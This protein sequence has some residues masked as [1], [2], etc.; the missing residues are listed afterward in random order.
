VSH[1]R[2]D[3]AKEAQA[4]NRIAWLS[5]DKSDNDPSRFL[6]YCIAALRTIEANLAK[7]VLSAL[8]SL[9]PP[10]AEEILTVLINEINALPDRIILVLDDFHL[11]EAQPVHDAITFLLDYM[12]P[13][14]HLVIATR[15]DPQL[16]LARLRARGQLTELRA[17]DLRFTSAKAA[18]FLNQVMGLNLSS[19]DIA[20][21]ESRTEGWIAGLQLAAISM[22][23]NRDAKSFIKSFTGS[24]RYVL[25][26][27]ID[28]VL[29]QQ[30]ASIQSFM[31]QTAILDRLSGDLC[32]AVTGQEN[33]QETLEYLD[34]ANLFIVPLDH[35][36]RWYRYHHLFVD[37]LRQRLRQSHQEQLPILHR[38]ASEWYEQH[39]FTGEAIE[40]SL[41]AN[42]FERAA[43]L[44]ELAWPAM[45]GTFQSAAWLGWVKALPE[46]LVHLRPV[47]SAAY[48]WALLDTGD[49]EASEARLRDAEIWLEAI[50]DTSE[51]PEQMVVVDEEQFR[52]L[53]ATI[54]TART[55]RAQALGD[56]SN[57]IKYAQRALDLL[58]DGDHLTHGQISAILGLAYWAAGDLEA[59]FLAVADGMSSMQMAGNIIFAISTTFVQA[60][61]REAQGR[62]HEAKSIYEQSLQLTAEH[63]EAPLPVTA[64]LHVGLGM[65][66][67]EQGDQQAAAKHLMI[68]KELGEES[69]LADWPYRWCLAQARIKESQGD[70]D[71]ALDFFQRAK[72]QYFRGAIP[73]VCPIDALKARVWIRQG[74][75]AEALGWAQE[76][77]LS[78]DNALSYLHEFEHI[79]L[80]RLTIA[81]GNTD[82][83]IELLRRLL[84]AAEA[85]GRTGSV[86]E[87]LLL[88]A[89]SLQAQG[90]TDQA[91]IP[92]E[93]ALTLAE[94]EGFIRVFVDQGPPLARLL[95][96][97]LSRG[98]APAYAQQLLGEFPVSEYER[99][100]SSQT[101]SAESGLIEPLSDRELEVLQL[102]A[103]GLT[104]PEIAS[105]LYISPHTVKVHTSNIYG[106]LAVGNRTQAVV[107][108]KSLGILQSG[109][110][111]RGG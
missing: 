51:Q 19:D 80:A 8:Q 95:Y 84:E 59:A 74:R 35:D 76:R 58:P 91:I 45:N 48:A 18:E 49:L 56:V 7:G 16:P 13:L 99:A 65:I 88:Q 111:S 92:L 2:F 60:Y 78:V 39:G 108:A 41:C 61:M 36:R 109:Q 57:T 31:L 24:H 25:D 70:L 10:P 71:G 86:I 68:S 62:L 110:S 15:D 43:S 81:Q 50:G 47:L 82:G 93:K 37:L 77:G 34:Q 12:P 98:I 26:Y 89:L 22:Q 101:E 106:K 28:E 29:E 63:D 14:L 67:H 40:N 11:I 6:S 103:E 72:D 42:D 38:R 55:Y 79:T 53:P 69:G 102:M 5:L 100:E 105:R 17:A 104:N 21:L 27:L 44:V 83:A 3:G 94:P 96:K 87:I 107:R 46:E 9:Q 1:L 73:D 66:H 30:P 54:A 64:T 90:N 97:A 85:G 20:T 52:S 4:G 32:A 75:L 23:N 33:G